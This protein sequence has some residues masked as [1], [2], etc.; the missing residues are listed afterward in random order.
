[1]NTTTVELLKYN[2]LP[3]IRIPLICVS[4]EVDASSFDSD[5]RKCAIIPMSKKSVEMLRKYGACAS[6]VVDEYLSFE[7][8]SFEKK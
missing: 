3:T 8:F 7:R 5:P 4:K 2:L 1:M 6:T